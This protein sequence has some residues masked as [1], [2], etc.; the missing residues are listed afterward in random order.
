[1][2][3]TVM[4][5]FLPDTTASSR[6]QVLFYNCYHVLMVMTEFF[7]ASRKIQQKDK[8]VYVTIPENIVFATKMHHMEGNCMIIPPSDVQHLTAPTQGGGARE[9]RRGLSD[10]LAK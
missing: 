1:M 6:V 4:V 5:S 8:N 10:G 3:V 7:E 2:Y 9:R